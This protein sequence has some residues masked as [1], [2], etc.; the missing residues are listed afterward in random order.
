MSPEKMVTMAN[1]IATFFDSQPGAAAERIA[2][3][4]R[5]YWEPRMRAQLLTFLQNGGQGL[6]P[7]VV[8]AARLL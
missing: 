5:D 8:E 6:K 3:H 4:L 1:Q 2:A 7:S